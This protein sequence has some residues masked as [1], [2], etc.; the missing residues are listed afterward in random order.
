M[1]DLSRQIAQTRAALKRAQEP[2]SKAALGVIR[3]H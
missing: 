2:G 3:V 1:G